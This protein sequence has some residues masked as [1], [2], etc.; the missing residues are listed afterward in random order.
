[1]AQAMLGQ[2]NFS[3]IQSQSR[4]EQEQKDMETL[5]S[6]FTESIEDRQNQNSSQDNNVVPKRGIKRKSDYS[7][8]KVKA[9]NLLTNFSYRHFKQSDFYKNSLIIDILSFMVQNFN[10]INLAIKLEIEKEREMVKYMWDV[11]VP[12]EFVS[13]MLKQN[14]YNIIS[15]PNLTYQKANSLVKAYLFEDLSRINHL[16]CKIAERFDLIHSIYS[17]LYAKI[18]NRTNSF[19]I[20]RK[21][22]FDFQFQIWRKEKQQKFIAKEPNKYVDRKI[23]KNQQ[24]PIDFSVEEKNPFLEEVNADNKTK[25]LNQKRK[26][27][28]E[29]LEE[30][31][32]AMKRIKKSK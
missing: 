27:L 2:M 28:E 30:N 19:A 23:E 7:N 11:C 20:Q 10:P 17:F 9:K 18:Y 1:M 24:K 32:R 21:N 4:V 12:H 25:K 13:F 5:L 22:D 26:M 29:K 8:T 15:Q 31:T 16:K 6:T 3:M 14:N